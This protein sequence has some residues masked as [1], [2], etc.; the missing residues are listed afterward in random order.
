MDVSSSMHG[1]KIDQLKTALG[2]VVGKLSPM[3]RLSIITFSNFTRKLCPLWQI[4]AASK[5]KLQKL[6][7]KL[8]P[9]LHRGIN[10]K[11]G[12]LTGLKVFPNCS[13]VSGG[14][15][16]VGIMLMSDGQQTTGDVSEVPVGNVPVYT[17]GF[18]ADSDPR[19]L[20]A[21][22]VNSMGGTFSHIQD[23]DIGGGGLTMAFAQCLAGLLT[24]AVQDLKLT[25]ATNGHNSMIEKVTAGSYHR[26]PSIPLAAR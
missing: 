23:Q 25:M 6:I 1:E 2:F 7:N 11:D 22:S 8:V 17:F 18:S 10:M 5:Q 13:K 9:G 19:V 21:V 16:I 15:R 26:P 20:N 3:D 12:L 4:T 14:S 24:V